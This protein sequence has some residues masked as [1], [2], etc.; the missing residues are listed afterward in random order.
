LGEHPSLTE[1]NAGLDD[2][3]HSI[4]F[5][6]TYATI[7]EHWLGVDSQEMLGGSFEL[8]DFIRSRNS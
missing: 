6:S 3:L 1:L 7:L 8:L 5:R 2:T 4:D